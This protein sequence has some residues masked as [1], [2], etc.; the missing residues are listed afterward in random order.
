VHFFNAPLRD[1][2]LETEFSLNNILELPQVDILYDHQ[3]AG[4]HLYRAAIDA[5]A[6]GL[7]LAGWAM[8][9]CLRQHGQVQTWHAGAAW[10]S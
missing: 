1:H 5:G 2:T 7:V 3:A 10:C 9:A 4:T 6:K 8:A